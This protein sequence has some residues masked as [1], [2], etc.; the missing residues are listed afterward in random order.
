MSCSLLE[1]AWREG[2]LEDGGTLVHCGSATSWPDRLKAV[3]DNPR[4]GVHV[5]GRLCLTLQSRCNIASGDRGPDS[6]LQ[7][8]PVSLNRSIW[9]SS[10]QR[11]IPPL[12]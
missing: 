7:V 11:V 12:L 3:R 5:Q 2:P 8:P 9:P 4:C 1:T 6:E 10:G